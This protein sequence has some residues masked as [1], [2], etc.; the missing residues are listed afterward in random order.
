MANP[1]PI[2]PV[3][4][5]N[6]ADSNLAYLIDSTEVADMQS[7]CPVNSVYMADH[8]HPHAIDST[9]VANLHLPQAVDSTTLA[10][11]IQDSPI[12][13]ST[14]ADCDS[15][16]SIDSCFLADRGKEFSLREVPHLWVTNPYDPLPFP[17][18]FDAVPFKWQNPPPVSL[19]GAAAFKKL[20]NV[21]EDVFS[22]HF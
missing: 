11:T 17:E 21:R 8:D 16:P 3:D 20:I 10:N 19:I 2:G 4:S 9:L 6:T 14:L 5:D 18:E 1:Q 7:S 12:Y 15:T 22:L 13:S